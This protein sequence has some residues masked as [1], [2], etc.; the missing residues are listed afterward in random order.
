MTGPTLTPLLT[1]REH[2]ALLAARDAAVPSI[3]CTLDLGLTSTEVFVDADGSEIPTEELH[4][5][6]SRKIRFF[7]VWRYFHRSAGTSMCKR[8]AFRNRDLQSVP[9][10]GGAFM[11]DK[12]QQLLLRVDQTRLQSQAGG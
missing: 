7:H 1:L 11:G 6:V 10:V 12:R 9:R 5:Q 8:V 3:E 2:E 4:S